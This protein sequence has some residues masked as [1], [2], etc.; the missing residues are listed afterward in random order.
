MKDRVRHKKPDESEGEEE[1]GI[2]CFLSAGN[3]LENDVIR[4]KTNK[5]NWN[6]EKKTTE[7]RELSSAGWSLQVPP[8]NLRAAG[9]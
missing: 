2:H 3:R 6:S 9:N 8:T 7:K 4:Q 1:E 5:E